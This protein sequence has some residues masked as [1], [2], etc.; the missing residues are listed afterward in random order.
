MYSASK[1]G[2]LVVIG[3]DEYVGEFLARAFAV[4]LL[5]LPGFFFGRFFVQEH[6]WLNPIH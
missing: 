6:L 2:V 5:R 1:A 3:A 4:S